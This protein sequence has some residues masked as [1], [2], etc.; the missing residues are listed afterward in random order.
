MKRKTILTLGAVAAVAV[1]GAAS[2]PAIAGGGPWG[3]GGWGPG[4][5][6][7]HHDM[8]RADMRH[9]G[10]MGMAGLA[11]NPVLQSFDADKDGKVTAAE[12]EAGVTALLTAH[13]ADK[14]G[15]LS[16]AE[17]GALF[18]QVTKSMAA[19]PFAMLDDDGDKAISAEEM[20]FP[21]K[22]MARMGRL[23]DIPVTQPVQP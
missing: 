16:E 7:G 19:R 21:V 6:M 9:G 20:T 8:G 1:I 22:M 5:M 15:T 18:A 3:M 17:F 11:D 12:A 10:P 13:D 4:P 23:T 14:S 2:I